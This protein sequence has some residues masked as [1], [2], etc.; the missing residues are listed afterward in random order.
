MKKI[1][2]ILLLTACSI[3]AQGQDAVDLIPDIGGRGSAIKLYDETGT[4]ANFILEP[5]IDGEGGYFN[6]KNGANG[7]AL[8]VDGMSG[9][10]T[11]VR[12]G[13]G[14]T[15]SM[16]NTSMS[17]DLSAKFPHDAISSAEIQNETG[18]T[19]T[20]KLTPTT[21][22][23]SITVLASTTITAPSDGFVLVMASGDF[24]T[25]HTNGSTSA[26]NI[27]IS[28]SLSSIA[29]GNS[30]YHRIPNTSPSGVYVRPTSAHGMFPVVAGTSTFY[31]VGDKIVGT[32]P[33]MDDATISA[34]FIPTNYGA[35][36]SN[37]T[38][39]NSLRSADPDNGG[40]ISSTLTLNKIHMDKE[41]SIDA[42][43]TRIKKELQEMNAQLELME[44][45]HNRNK[46]N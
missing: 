23:T 36:N 9:S 15:G 31:F 10:G 1:N 5:D 6:I 14:Y 37:V 35:I 30:L 8:E 18:V 12:M 43:E 19:N 24:S 40:K 42:N 32:N 41:R 44:A 20:T 39:D 25:S 45:N 27:G 33:T 28:T 34:I 26:T 21:I 17:G 16:F 7:T 29:S 11:R 38:E 13:S 22:T 2:L 4:K 46:F 3:I